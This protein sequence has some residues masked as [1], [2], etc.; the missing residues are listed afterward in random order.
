MTIVFQIFS[1]APSAD[2][3]QFYTVYLK[4]E[5]RQGHPLGLVNFMKNMTAN[6]DGVTR[7]GRWWTL[8]T[9][10]FMHV[11]PLH[12]L[13]NMLSMYYIGQ[14]LVNTPVFSTTRLL[15]L[16]LGSGIAGTVGHLAFRAQKIREQE[17]KDGPS[18]YGRRDHVV[19]LGASGCVMGVGTVAA[20]LYPT[21]TFQIYGIIPV[22]LW[23]LM[24]GYAVY[25]GYYLNSSNSRIGHA[26]H[27]GGGAFGVLYYFF[28]LRGM[29]VPRF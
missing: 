9:P 28:S 16:I 29:R 5:A 3:L 27:L 15:I 6:L 13:G 25:D 14:L 10:C 22:P 4:E 18:P 8:V 20:F 17:A 26:G 2:R 11:E 19:A 1:K 7:E 12:I 23:V 21:T 24:A